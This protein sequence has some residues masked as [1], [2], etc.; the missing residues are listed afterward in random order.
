MHQPGGARHRRRT[1]GRVRWT[2]AGGRDGA[3]F[4]SAIAALRRRRDAA[5]A[6]AE[7]FE[8]AAVALEALA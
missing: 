4:G 6:E 3:A 8:A 1:S 5:R 7:K 2:I